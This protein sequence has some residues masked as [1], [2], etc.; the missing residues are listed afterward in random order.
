LKET[1]VNISSTF[2]LI[3]SSNLALAIEVGDSELDKENLPQVEDL[4]SIDA[5]LATIEE[6]AGLFD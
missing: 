3:G 6:E 1:C 4:V 5:R 2:F